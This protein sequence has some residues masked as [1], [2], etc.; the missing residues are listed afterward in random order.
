MA[1]CGSPGSPQPPSLKIPT[2]VVDLSTARTG[3]EVALHW[4]MPRRA[5]DRVL[6]AGDQRVVICR[7]VA[8][9]P[10]SRVGQLLLEA[11]KPGAYTDSLPPELSSGAPKL[12]TY[13]VLL[14]NH[15]RHDAGPSNRAYAAAGAA[16]PEVAGLTA[17]A[18]ARGIVLRW[19]Q[20]AR[21][22]SGPKAMAAQRLVRLQRTRVLRPGE[23]GKPTTE[24]NQAGVPQPVD[25]TLEVAEPALTAQPETLR[26]GWGL[27]H[28][29]D[30]DAAL[31]RIY[32]YT[33]QQVARL[34][35]AGHQ[36]EVSSLPTAGATVD[37]K[38]VFPPGVPVGLEA[39]AD[40]EGD[41]IDLSWTPDSDADGAGYF[42]YR[43]LAEGAVPGAPQKVSGKAPV[44]NAAWRDTAAAT[45]VRYAYSVSAVDTSG[46]ESSRSPEVDESVTPVPPDQKPPRPRP[47][48]GETGAPTKLQAQ[49]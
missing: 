29:I 23:S 2:P 8:E 30:Q 36:V 1:G 40:A 35:L 15:S 13:T 11:G 16:P 10:C 18:E 44:V 49:K 20:S 7:S 37:A 34:T 21:A 39:V 47:A 27:D 4:T 12:L 25:Q 24:E 9:A 32:R 26:G 5:T 45:G 14:E 38:D 33:V 48:G 28:A 3:N 42:V 6:L 17:Q 46:N 41:A 43:R 31:N 22:A 19:A